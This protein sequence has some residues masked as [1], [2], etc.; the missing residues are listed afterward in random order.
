MTRETRKEEIIQAIK[1]C[2]QEMGRTPTVVELLYKKPL[3]RGSIYRAFGNYRKALEACGLEGRGPG[4]QIAP[5]KLF[6]DWCGV[7]RKLGKLPAVAE[8]DMN[9]EYTAQPLLSR[10][11]S[12]RRVPA[13]MQQYAREWG[14]AEEWADVMKMIEEAQSTA[15][16]TMPGEGENEHEYIYG[17]PLTLSPMTYAPTCE[18]GV[19]F[20]FGALAGDLGFAVEHVQA[21]FPDIT[22]LRQVRPGVWRRVRIECEMESRNFVM[23]G[24]TAGGCDLIVCWEH[25][26]ESCPVEVIELKK[27][28]EEMA[29]RAGMN[30]VIGRSGHREIGTPGKRVSKDNGYQGGTEVEE[31][32]RASECSAPEAPNEAG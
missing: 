6:L 13:A 28:M 1:E 16:S 11:T 32:K 31:S 2:A 14:M 9:G 4:F 29:A 20:L 27:V 18:N 26:W 12:W 19:L 7:A 30:R 24:H 10:Y 22:A 3:R 25:N 21:A 8:Y 15:R 23:H 17:T 5:K